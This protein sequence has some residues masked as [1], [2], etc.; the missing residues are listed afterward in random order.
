MARKLSRNLMNDIISLVKED[1]QRIDNIIASVQT[2]MIFVDDA[3]LPIEEGDKIIHELPNGQVEKYLILDTGF[4]KG[5]RMIPDHYQI[6]VRKETA[7]QD[8]TTSPVNQYIGTIIHG[9]VS[10]GNI[11]S[12]GLANAQVS[13]IVNDPALLQS[14][15]ETLLGKLLEEIK[16]ELKGEDLIQYVRAVDELKQ[17]LLDQER[18]DPSFFKRI[19]GTV[20]FLGSIDGTINLT[21]KAWPYIYPLLAVAIALNK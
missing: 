15:L 6:K 8:R 14:E 10:G 12:V 4:K 21:A 3:T 13:Q 18:S 11:L 1:G 16:P 19:I 5:L 2:E 9:N 7:V 20:S 17:Y